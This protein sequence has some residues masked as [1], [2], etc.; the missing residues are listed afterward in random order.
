MKFKA[1]ENGFNTRGK[2]LLGRETLSSPGVRLRR[3]ACALGPFSA[4]G[5]PTAGPAG[6][7]W[8]KAA[9][10]VP[11]ALFHPSKTFVEDVKQLSMSM[12]SHHCSVAGKKFQKCFVWALHSP[13]EQA[14]FPFSGPIIF[15]ELSLH[16]ARKHH[17]KSSRG[18][19]APPSKRC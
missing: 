4:D 17:S 14:I 12:G 13:S 19:E 9:G 1:P 15:S 2:W 5:V 11:G 3:R 10:R 18:A 7:E 16:W 6:L 8:G